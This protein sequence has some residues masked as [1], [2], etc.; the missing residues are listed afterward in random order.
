MNLGSRMP[1]SQNL[2]TSKEGAGHDAFYYHHPAM[3]ACT[4]RGNTAEAE[5]L[6]QLTRKKRGEPW[7]TTTQTATTQGPSYTTP[8]SRQVGT[9]RGRTSSCDLHGQN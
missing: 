7:A 6:P 3:Q 2:A 4:P 9:R 1:P 5:A 8:F